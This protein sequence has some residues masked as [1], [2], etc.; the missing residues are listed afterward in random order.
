MTLLDHADKILTKA[1][2]KY[3]KVQGIVI[4]DYDAFAIKNGEEFIRELTYL[5]LPYEEVLFLTIFWIINESFPNDFDFEIETKNKPALYLRFSDY[6]LELMQGENEIVGATED[7]RSWKL[8]STQA[9]HI[10]HQSALELGF[11]HLAKKAMKHR[12]RLIKH[13]N[14]K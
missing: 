3:E 9:H 7:D 4:P 10:V 11:H 5:Y 8:L 14:Q 6:D 1:V 2:K 13:L 12:D